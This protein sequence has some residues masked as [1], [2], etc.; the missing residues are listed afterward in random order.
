MN[1]NNEAETQARKDVEQLKF[2]HKRFNAL[3]IAEFVKLHGNQ[4]ALAIM[5]EC[6]ARNDA[7]R[8]KGLQPESEGTRFK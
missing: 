5:Q 2:V 8:K 7:R 1:E 4:A 3:D 6:V